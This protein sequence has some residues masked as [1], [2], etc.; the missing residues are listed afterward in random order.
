M[1]RAV[2]NKCYIIF[3]IIIQLA[4]FLTSIIQAIGLADILSIFNINGSAKA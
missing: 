2:P 4:K 3:I 1:S